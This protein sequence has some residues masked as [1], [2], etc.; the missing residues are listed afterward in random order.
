MT[1]AEV[2]Q[3]GKSDQI[4]FLESADP[5]VS[6]GQLL[7]E[8]QSAGMNFSDIMARLGVY[9]DIPRPPFRPG[10]EVSGRVT[11]IGK[12]VKCFS[13]GEGVAAIMLAGGGYATH[14][15]VDA[16]TAIKLPPGLDF[17]LAAGLMV[18][19]LT[20]YLLLKEAA[21]GK[22]DTVLISAAAGG[23][24][25]LAVQIARKRGARVVGLAS[26]PK[27]TF[28]KTLGADVAID[29]G[30]SGWSESVLSATKNKDVSVYHIAPGFFQ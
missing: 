3:F 29:Y 16:N 6:D 15:V 21:A 14:A 7:I 8:I 20:A 27:H 11:S 26:E 17:D 19:G 23:V 22:D 9:P 2:T 24:G 28:I 30:G 12:G 4:H 1:Y 25:S 13:V 10:F 18:Q 5:V